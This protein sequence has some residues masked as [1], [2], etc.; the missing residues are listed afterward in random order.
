MACGMM[1]VGETE[2]I[3]RTPNPIADGVER[4]LDD[5]ALTAA[6]I[7]AAIAFGLPTLGVLVSAPIVL[8]Q[9]AD[10]TPRTMLVVAGALVVLAVLATLAWT[11]PAMR[12]RR[13]TY[14]VDA[15]G[16]RI[17]RGIW[18]RSEIDVPRSRVQH[19]D[20]ARGPVERGLG[21]ATLVI[22]T[23]GTENASVSLSGLAHEV[24]TGIRDLLIEG[25][26]DDAV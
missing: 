2:M 26:S 12:H 20:V 19:T 18:W 10:S 24:A 22:F 1:P 23:A 3:D 7:G 15:L 25:G 4:H 11:V 9:W 5:R 16:I 6:R 14:R 21:L 8:F 13:I 17:R